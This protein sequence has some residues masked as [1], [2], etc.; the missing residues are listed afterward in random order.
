MGSGIPHFFVFLV[1]IFCT[2]TIQNTMKHM[3]LS[4]KIK[5]DVIF[6]H[7]LMLWFQ[8]YSLDTVSFRT[9]RTLSGGSWITK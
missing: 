7:F 5:G 6:D 8:K 4:L 2:K 1:T 3:K 9:F